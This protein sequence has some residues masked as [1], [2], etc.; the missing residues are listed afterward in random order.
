MDDIFSKFWSCFENQDFAQAQHFFDRLSDMD[1]QSVLS[2]LFQQSGHCQKPIALSVL[3]R[4]LYDQK[5]FN[6]S[7]QA[8]LPS[9]DD[10]QFAQQ[11]RQK[12]QQYFSLPTRV[13]N[14]VNIA[15]EKEVLSVSLVWAHNSDQEQAFWQ[16]I[17]KLKVGKDT[18]NAQRHARIQ[19]VAKGE[20]LGIY[21]TESDDNLG[22]PFKK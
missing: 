7:Y 10:C 9:S 6:E 3:R 4:Q 18:S 5:T 8:W 16:Y 11:G 22:T 1:K 15:N 12:F 19:Q 14:A 21:K 17:D 2:D 13:I 20:L